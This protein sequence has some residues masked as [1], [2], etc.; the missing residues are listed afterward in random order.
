MNTKHLCWLSFLSIVIWLV[1][2]CAAPT[3]V[4]ETA[5]PAAAKTSTPRP[6]SVPVSK[7]G[8]A[9]EALKGVTIE[10][11]HPWFGAEDSLFTS[12]VAKFNT[13][14]P[15]GIVVLDT[16]QVTYNNLYES[17]D[18]VIGTDQQ[19]DMIVA[20][21]DQA[22]AWLPQDALVDLTPYVNDP[23]YGL[24]QAEIADFP[25]VFW[26]Q[27][28]VGEAR[29]GVPAQRSARFLLYNQSWAR[30]LGFK[31]APRTAEE[32]LDQ[33]CAAHQSK[34]KDDSTA[35]DGQGGWIVDT[36]VMSLYSWMLAFDGGVVEGEGFRFLTPNN[37][38]TLKFLKSMYDEGCAWKTA[39]D[40]PY[41]RFAER[42]GLFATASLEEI[43]DQVR[44]FTAANNSDE[45]TVIPYPGADGS[46]F[47]V[48]G[49]SYVL[50]DS[51]DEQQ[52]AS[53]LFVRWLL[54][55]ENQARW[56]LSTG[57]FPVRASS[58]TEL[59]DYRNEHPQWAAAVDLLPQ[60][61]PQPELA[62]WRMVRVIMGDGFDH[63]FRMDIPSGQ[64][65]ATLA[66]MDRIVTELGYQP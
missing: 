10:V 1:S 18:A 55:P 31:T 13:D 53:W 6:T 38:A 43:P 59:A 29:W 34:L 20:L 46:D 19:P 44:A 56:V 58:M 42:A 35:N 32:F 49:S 11:W 27:D 14:N 66:E 12:Q 4:I 45:W 26:T 8:V 15:W 63:I 2:A 40:T 61:Q 62:A 9:E 51:S 41:Q 57:L 33:A 48:Y 65:A 24:T 5:A 52:L 3:E 17:V 36:N 60:G 28:Q 64:V 37:I 30:E 25:K 7:L 50:L 54:S 39:A 21:S 16:S 23:V 22:L 47:V